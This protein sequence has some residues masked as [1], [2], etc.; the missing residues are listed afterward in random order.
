MVDTDP[1]TPSARRMRGRVLDVLALLK[2]RDLTLFLSS[3]MVSQLGDWALVLA[4]PLFVFGRTHAISSTG[5][6]VALQLFPRLIVSPLAG[7]LAD[8]W[9]RKLTLIVADVVRAGVLLVLVVPAAGGPIWLVYAVALAE[10]S[11]YQLFVAADGALLPTIVRSEHLLRANS[12][13]SSGT[14]TI[15]LVGPAVGGLMFALLGL[16]GSAIMDSAALL[17]SA[18]LL[19]AIRVPAASRPPAAS[20]SGA[21]RGVV[22]G[23]V[24]ELADG[25]R[26]IV[27]SRVFEAI[28]V[29]LTALAVVQGMFETLLVPFVIDVLHFDPTRFGLLAASQGLGGLV[30]ALALGA[31]SRY[32]TSGRVVGVAIVLTAALLL[33][34]VVVR[35]L[36][37]SAAVLFLQGV[38]MVVAAAWMQTYYQQQVSNE[39]LG[40]VFGLT[41]T[42]S[43]VGIF[44]GIGAATL[45]GGH[46]GI[47]P[48]MLVGAAMALV[49]GGFAVVA[50]WGVRT[51]GPGLAP[52]D[53]EPAPGPEATPGRG[54][55]APETTP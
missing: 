37:L 5:V 16:A 40:R 6:L 34:F 7:V 10:A 11:T 17:I 38:P 30:G 39:L 20:E 3:G 55:A 47:V 23:F 50:L 35:P 46:L 45:F 54:A 53:E 43:S 26:C 44:T 14:A 8:R 21:P 41:E 12:L 49:N 24:R 1:P 19:V 29:V 32:M 9:N 13:L 33:C 36:P 52:S 25:V 42:A 22:S 4:L 28:F 48:L 51:T 27:T 15:R 18:A 2:D 31:F